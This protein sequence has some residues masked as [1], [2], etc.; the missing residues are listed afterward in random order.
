MGLFTNRWKFWKYNK[1]DDKNTP[2]D[3]DLA[4]NNNW[5]KIEAEGNA[6]FQG[7]RNINLP[8]GG[9]L[10]WGV[11]ANVFS[12]SKEMRILPAGGKLL[13]GGIAL[14][15]IKIAAGNVTLANSWDCMFITIPTTDGATVVPQVAQFSAITGDDK[16]ILAIRDTDSCLELFAGGWIVYGTIVAAG[17]KRD[18]YIDKS[19][20]TAANDFVLGN[21]AG[22]YIKKTLTETL[23]I[24]NGVASAVKLTTARVLGLSG[25][26][27]GSASFDGTANATIAVTLANT[28]VTAGTYTKV[29]VDAKGRVTSATQMEMTDIP[30]S[31]YKKSCRAAT[32]GN[33]TLSGVQTIDGVS[34]VAGDRV[35]VKNQTTSS[36][37]GIYNVSASAW[38]RAVDGDLSSEICAAVVNIDEGTTNGGKAFTNEFKATDTLGTTAMPWYE[39]I[40]SNVISTDGT[41]ASNS[42]TLVPTQKASKTYIDTK[43]AQLV[44]SSPSTLDTLQELANALGNDP[45]FATTMTNTLANK[46]DK[47]IFTTVNDFILGTGV[48]TFAKK[49][50]A[51]VR[52]I[53]QDASNRFVTDTEK[54]T[55]NGKLDKSLFTAINDFLVGTGANTAI[56]K[57]PSEVRTILNVE[58][59][60]T[61]EPIGAIAFIPHTSLPSGWLKANGAAISRT[62]YA[63]LFALI[64]TTFGAGDGSTTFNLPDLRGEFIRGFDDGRGIDTGRILGNSQ[65]DAIRNITGYFGRVDSETDIYSGAF[66]NYGAVSYDANSTMSGSGKYVG[67]DAS[68]IVPTASENRPRNIALLA[69]IKF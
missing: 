38:A 64:G 27:T 10:R 2:F 55:W 36:Q 25:D 17:G 39:I 63:N 18:T 37:N 45:N 30:G 23:A 14:T 54:S 40:S 28:G 69:I 1:N 42:D 46:V 58:D 9:E 66:F 3:L 4:L 16:L 60:A 34:V 33:I 13:P 43:V 65:G 19:I 61:K 11:V 20:F 41:M 24:L 59:G 53:L 47:S 7:T 52:T 31:S 26:A 35:L 48:G 22:A 67:F 57:T 21:G 29:T 8:G 32:T 15:N 5:D 44:N 51:E 12:W 6:T 50:L 56:K 49:T 62:T 68:R